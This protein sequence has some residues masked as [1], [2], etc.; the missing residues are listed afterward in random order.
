M[1][2]QP[3]CFL[4]RR[5]QARKQDSLRIW[6]YVTHRHIELHPLSSCCKFDGNDRS[7]SE[8]IRQPLELVRSHELLNEGVASS[9]ITIQV[10]GQDREALLGKGSLISIHH[11]SADRDDDIK[12][13]NTRNKVRASKFIGLSL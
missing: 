3:H 7:I 2:C 9:A 4:P 8:G 1:F 5:R 13:G 10:R 6:I 11:S 12:G